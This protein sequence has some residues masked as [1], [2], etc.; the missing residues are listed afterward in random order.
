MKVI[1]MY[2]IIAGHIFPI[3]HEYIYVFS[4]PLFF[5]ISGYLGHRESSNKLFWSKLFRNLILPCIVI[6]LILHTEQTF[7]Q[8][9]LGSFAWINIPTHIINCLIGSLALHT[10]AGGIG[11]CWFIYTLAL[12]KII[13]QYIGQ[14]RVGNSLVL[15]VCITIAVLYNYNDLH[16]RNAYFNTSLAYPFYAMGGG[17]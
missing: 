16:L 10:D 14:C 1:G 8:I 12:C 15:I 13:Q 9:R 5:V 17:V 6:L 11:I 2:F 3:G 4:V 7:A